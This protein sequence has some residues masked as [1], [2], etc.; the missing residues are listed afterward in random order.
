MN[1]PN[2][3]AA[4]QAGKVAPAATERS[5]AVKVF[6]I[7]NIIFALLGLCGTVMGSVMFFVELPQDPNFPN[8]ALDLMHENQTYRMYMMVSMALGLIF[9]IVL[10][11]GGFGLLNW[12]RYGRSASLAYGWFGIVS[13]IAGA[14]MNYFFLVAPMMAQA[15]QLEGQDQTVAMGGAIG[16]AIGGLGGS[17][18]GLIYPIILIIFMNRKNVINSLD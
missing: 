16:G 13:V 3:Y 11:V 5:S 15:Q 12:K 10:A 9:S 14:F 18:F 7:L 8:P 2:P 17:C 6:G 4:T 1:D